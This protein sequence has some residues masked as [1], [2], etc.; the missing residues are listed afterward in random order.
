MLQCKNLNDEQITD[1]LE[2]IRTFCEIAYYNFAKK[3]EGQNNG[4]ENISY[5]IAC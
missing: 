2:T 1:L 5:N 3:K 4:G